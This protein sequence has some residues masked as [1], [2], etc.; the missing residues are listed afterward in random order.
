VN[1]PDV[2]PLA[3]AWRQL[4]AEAAADLS[5][6]AKPWELIEFASPPQPLRSVP[7]KS[8]PK[9]YAIPEGLAWYYVGLTRNSLRTRI[10]GH[11][12]DH[13]RRHSWPGV[14]YL[15]LRDDISVDR[16]HHLER[17]GREILKPLMGER[18]SRN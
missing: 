4:I 14:M 2:H 12:R 18:W 11:F 8:G 16:F 6:D 9:I 3:P 17:V 10:E 15:S 5:E 13:K 7:A 1:L